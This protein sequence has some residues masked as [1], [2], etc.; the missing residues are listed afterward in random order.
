MNPLFLGWQAAESRRWYPIGRLISY[1]EGYQ[2][3][4]TRGALAART[5]A[6]FDFLPSFPVIGAIYRSEQLFPL[7]RN[8]LLPRSRPDYSAFLH[9]MNVNEQNSDPM[10]LL[11]RSGGQKATDNLLVFHSPEKDEDGRYSIRFFP[12]GLRHMPAASVER[13]GR[14]EAGE[15]LLLMHD[16]QNPK[17]PNALMLRT[18]GVQQSDTHLLGFVPRYLIED[19]MTLLTRIPDLPRTPIVTV[20]RMNPPPAPLQYRLLCRA[21]LPWPAGFT[22]FSG[23]EFEEIVEADDPRLEAVPSLSSHER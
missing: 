9:W 13:A 12:H 6:G 20:E 16:L 4:Y 8:R 23:D 11:S 7:F 19:I 3:T 17:D 14:L 22:P 1:R 15:S 2:F 10:T 18:E 5:D 21:V